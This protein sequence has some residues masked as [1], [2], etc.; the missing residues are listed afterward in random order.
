MAADGHKATS[1]SHEAAL[2]KHLLSSPWRMAD[3][4]LPLF[5]ILL[6]GGR[7]G[8]WRV[9]DG[10]WQLGKYEVAA[11]WWHRDSCDLEGVVQPLVP[12]GLAR[13]AAI[14]QTQR[15]RLARGRGG[16]Q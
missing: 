5:T 15:G 7:D 13:G 1:A 12:C 14:D 6:G 10:T 9:Q 8:T 4:A 3:S 16:C 11:C 2:G